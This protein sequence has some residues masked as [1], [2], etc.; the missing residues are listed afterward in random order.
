MTQN[1]LKGIEWQLLR[2]TLIFAVTC[3]VL[4]LSV[5]ML[6]FEY[7][8]SKEDEFENKKLELLQLK[9]RMN[10]ALR[11]GD[12]YKEHLP[13]LDEYRKLGYVGEENRVL[14]I[15]IIREV[16]TELKFPNLQYAISEQTPYEHKGT[17][18]PTGDFSIV[19]SV[20]QIG[21]NIYHEGDLFKLIKTLKNRSKGLFYIDKC[22]IKRERVVDSK[23]IDNANL[24]VQCDLI[25]IS[26]KY[27]QLMSEQKGMDNES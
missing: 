24:N 1:Y 8:L 22:A 6:S 9:S 19:K 3:V 25:W 13:S 10:K 4:G 2:G 11:D 23:N 17:E 15:D 18:L 21:M 5:L 26:V 12:T 27:E 20:M 16:T 7:K 14:W